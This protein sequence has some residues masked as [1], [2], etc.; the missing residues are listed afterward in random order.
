MG[1]GNSRESTESSDGVHVGYTR[2]STIAQTLDQQNAALDSAGVTKIF[3]DTRSGARDDRPGLAALLDCVRPGGRLLRRDLHGPQDIARIDW[4]A[5]RIATRGA[6]RGKVT[7]TA[8]TE[9][10]WVISLIG[11][12]LP[13]VRLV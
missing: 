11:R 4:C 8:S 6:E 9:V 3:S 13:P 5:R 10:C 12:R 2:V 1:R 7:S